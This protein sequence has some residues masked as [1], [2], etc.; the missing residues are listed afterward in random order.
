MRN[1]YKCTI[2]G[3]F[4][5]DVMHC[6]SPTKLILDGGLRSKLS[7]LMTY[8][9]R[10]NPEAIGL[11]MDHEGWVSIDELVDAVRT[12]WNPKAY[13]WL[14]KEHVIAIALLDPKGRFEMRNGMIRARYGHNKSLNVNIKYEIDDAV[15]TL[16][17]GTTKEALT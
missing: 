16:Y 9:L 3:A 8:L 4:T 11:A 10:H 1:I 15:K 12:R 2:C 5:E 13:S 6:G 17:H 14:T 7:R